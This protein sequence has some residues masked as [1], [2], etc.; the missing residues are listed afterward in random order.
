[1][2]IKTKYS[3]HHRDHAEGHLF[4][5]KK[6][7]CTITLTGAAAMSQ[8]ELDRFGACFARAVRVASRSWVREGIIEE[9]RE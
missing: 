6:G 3:P 8:E 5:D 9:N 4:I 2:R 1:M 7:A